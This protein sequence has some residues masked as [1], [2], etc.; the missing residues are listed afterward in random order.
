[1]EM[2]KRF[3]EQGGRPRPR[4]RTLAAVARVAQRE[5]RAGAR[6]GEVT[7]GVVLTPIQRE[8]FER[9][10]EQAG[11]YNQALMLKAR[12][13][14]EAEALRGALGDVLRQH[15]A[16]RLRYRRDAAGEWQQE[17]ASVA[18]AEEQALLQELG[19]EATSDVYKLDIYGFVDFTYHHRLA[20]F[21]FNAPYNSFAVGNFNLYLS[22]DLGDDWRSLAEVRFT[23]LPHGNQT[24]DATGTFT[25]TDT[26][27]ADYT[28]LGRPLRWG[29]VVIERAWLEYTAHPLL[30]VRGGHW[31]TPYGI[32]N[33]DHGSPVIIGVRRPFIVGES[34]FPASQTGLELYGTQGFDAFQLG[35]HLTLSNGRG[36]LDRYQDLNANKAIGGRLFGRLD[37]S[38]G[39]VT[40]GL[41]AYRGDYTDRSQAFVVDA[42][43]TFSADFPRTADYDELSYAADLKWEYSGFWLQSEAIV[44]EVAFEDGYRPQVLFATEG[45][46]GYA[47]D[48]RRLGVYG[49]TGYRFDFIGLMP[50]TGAEYYQVG[51]DTFIPEAAAFFLGLNARPTARVVLKVQYTYSWNPDA[52]EDPEDSHYN[53]IDS[54][55]AWSF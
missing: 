9:E 33:V 16:L 47:P 6:Q 49:L 32:W 19:G 1:M 4:A 55:V 53:A 2:M 30:T 52:A 51:G 14:L 7:G 21:S 26:T 17:H 38:L 44:N 35:Y 28:D 5:A 8:Y 50:F 46:P 12:E 24:A 37:S 45:P 41:S 42:E 3:L 34:L 31:L 29:G 18:A 15:D 25:R 22:S 13:K 43:G 39:T 48:F 27:V 20:D 54:Q 36:P 23:Y 10:R 40:L 11:H